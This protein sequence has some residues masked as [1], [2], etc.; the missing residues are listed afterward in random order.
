MVGLGVVGRNLLLNMAD[1]GFSRRVVTRITQ[2]SKPLREESKDRAVSGTTDIKEFI[3]LLGKPRAVMMLVPSGDPVDSVIKDLFAAFGQGR[4][5][6]YI[7]AGD[8]FKGTGMRSRNLT[9]KGTFKHFGNGIRE[10]YRFRR[11]S[12]QRNTA[13][14]PAV[15][16]D[17]CGA[18]RRKSHEGEAVS[19]RA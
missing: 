12:K 13:P 9:A 17:S 1:R 3:A 5:S 6:N 11:V 14:L 10:A 4:S 2:R 18:N 7:D 19:N 16:Y 8:C 15:I